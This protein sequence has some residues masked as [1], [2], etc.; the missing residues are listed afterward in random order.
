MIELADYKIPNAPD[1]VHYIPNFISAAEEAFILRK[2]YE[3]PKP[4]WTCLKNRRLQDYGGIP[5]PKGMITEDMPSWLSSYIDKI[6]ELGIFDASH[7]CNHVLVNEYKVNQ[8]IMAH[9]DGD[10]FHPVI[11]TISCGFHTI[12][13]FEENIDGASKSVCNLLLEPRSL[14]LLSNDMYTKY[15]HAIKERQIDEINKDCV[16]LEGCYGNYKVGSIL[17]RDT[18]VSLTIRNVLKVSK[19]NVT[20]LFAKK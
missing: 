16:N 13:E 12:L 7:K 4:K 3:V 1:T 17:R 15:M 14:V 2:V 6:N 8:G 9:F 18:R 20:H 11:A 10:L 19:L 5:H